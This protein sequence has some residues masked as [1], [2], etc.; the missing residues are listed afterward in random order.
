MNV[1][2]DQGLLLNILIAICAVLGLR[3]GV[4]K[5]MAILV[6]VILGSLLAPMARPYIP[7]LL[8]A[9]L[10]AFA[11]LTKSGGAQATVTTLAYSKWM[12]LI[13]FGAILLLSLVVSRLMRKPAKGFSSRLFGTLVGGL[14]GYLIG[15]FVFPRL[16]AAPETV[17]TISGLKTQSH[18][19][20]VNTAAAVVV[21]IIVLIGLGIKQSAPPKKKQA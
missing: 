13:V 5:E 12:D 17:L 1:G 3:R 9:G 6:G 18:F 4:A 20:P 16:L 19:S 8:T 10:K 21:F 11:G 15:R 2:L 7:A 14:N